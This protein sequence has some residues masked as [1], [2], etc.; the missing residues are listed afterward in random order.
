MSLSILS[1]NVRGLRNNLKRRAIFNFCRDRA[2]VICLQETHST[3]KDEL[4]WALEWGGPIYFSHGNS[5]SKGVCILIDRN[6][7]GYVLCYKI[8]ITYGSDCIFTNVLP[9]HRNNMQNKF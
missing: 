8:Y 6:W 9:N 4:Q 7:I 1:L 3:E 5:D 2:N